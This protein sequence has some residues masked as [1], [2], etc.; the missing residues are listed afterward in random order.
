MVKQDA[1]AGEEVIGLSVID[2]HPVRIDLCCAVKDFVD[3]RAL[4]LVV[5]FP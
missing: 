2:R 4:F 1:I 3:K 5:V